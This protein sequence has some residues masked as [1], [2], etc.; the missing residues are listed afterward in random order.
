MSKS[1][2]DD[3]EKMKRLSRRRLVGAVTLTTIIV[4]MLPIVL[5]SEPGFIKPDIDLRIPDKETAGE[6]NPKLPTAAPVE[7]KIS[8]LSGRASETSIPTASMPAASTSTSTA[9]AP[10]VS[11]KPTVSPVEAPPGTVSIA[12][13]ATKEKAA[14]A[15]ALTHPAP[16][17]VAAAP[18]K[19]PVRQLTKNSGSFVIQVGAFT[20][21]NSANDLKIQL[22]QMNIKA[23]TEKIDD[24]TRVRVGPYS[25]K[26][27]ADKVLKK[28][29]AQG[30]MPVVISPAANMAN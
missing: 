17:K 18:A 24:K 25:T 30:L 5:D 19:P 1:T 8:D 13:A 27:A 6:F 28:L 22:S 12:P 3:A 16:N 29:E 26:A 11:V 7:I 14:P 4:V 20:N 2:M 10:T 9:S 23:Y 15:K 21:V